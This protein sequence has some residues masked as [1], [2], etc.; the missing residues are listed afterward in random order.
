MLCGIKICVCSVYK[1]QKAIYHH[2]IMHSVCKHSPVICKSGL[3][4]FGCATA[5]TDSK[6][7]DLQL[8]SQNAYSL[9]PSVHLAFNSD[10]IQDNCSHHQNMKA[11]NIY[12]YIYIYVCVCVCVCIYIYIYIQDDFVARGRKLLS[13]KIMLL[14]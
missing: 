1:Q 6:F 2:D 8:E 12:I 5:L 4:V 13:I 7:I 10:T 3:Q 11:Y 9:T 14:R